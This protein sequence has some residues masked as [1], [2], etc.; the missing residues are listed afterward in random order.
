M[1]VHHVDDPAWQN[2]IVTGFFTPD[3]FPLADAFSENLK[4]FGIPHILYNVP[5][6]AWEQAILL[7]PQIVDLAMQDFPDRT[8]ILMDIDCIIMAPIDPVLAFNGDVSLFM[9]VRFLRRFTQKR[10]SMRVLPSSRIIAWRPTPMAKVLLANW[11]R[12]CEEANSN[13]PDNDDEQI[14]MM[15]IGITAGVSVTIIDGR[16][17]ARDPHYARKDA[18]IIHDSAHNAVLSN[19]AKIRLRNIKRTFL[20]RLLRRPYPSPRRRIANDGGAVN[21]D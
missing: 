13:E 6:K 2:A 11:G 14:L 5:Q 7:K 10:T 20:S 17:S 9:G 12:L 15:A 1:I 8:I 19:T 3:Y 16:Y 18:V 4:R 21:A